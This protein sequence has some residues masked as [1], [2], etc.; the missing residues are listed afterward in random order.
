MADAKLIQ[1][2]RAG[3]IGAPEIA[4]AEARNA[5]LDLAFACALLEKESGG[6]ANVFGHDRDR[7]RNYIFPAR[8]GVVPVTEEQWRRVEELSRL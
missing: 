3:G 2:L 6:G 7:N 5:G 8:D 1:R 4:I